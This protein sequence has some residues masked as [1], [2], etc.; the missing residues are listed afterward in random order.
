VTQDRKEFTTGG[1]TSI[2]GADDDVGVTGAHEVTAITRAGFKVGG[3]SIEMSSGSITMQ[4]AAGAKAVFDPA[5]IEITCDIFIVVGTAVVR[6]AAPH[7]AFTFDRLSV[8]G[9]SMADLQSPALM[10]N[11]GGKPFSRLLDDAPDKIANGAA[12]VTV[13]E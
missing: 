7:T 10:L 12:T 4:T 6:V 8:E 2:V 1:T 5:K 9:F 13:G 3:T 11:G